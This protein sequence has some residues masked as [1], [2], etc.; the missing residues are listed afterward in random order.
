MLLLASPHRRSGV[1][2]T[3]PDL[4]VDFLEILMW[5][6]AWAKSS[7]PGGHSLTHWLP[8]YRH[9]DDSAAVAR[10]L[11]ERWVPEQVLD[12][13]AEDL[14]DGR[15]GV[16]VVTSWL[17]GVHDVG[18]LSPAFVV[19]APALADLM[20]RHG[21]DASPRLAVDQ[22]RGKVTHALVG[23]HAVRDWLA[24]ELGFTRRHEA[25]QWAVVIGGHHGVPP[26]PGQ[27]ALVRQ[28]SDLSGTGVWDEARRAILTRAT[29]AVGGREA[30][31]IYR[32]ALLSPPSQ[33][34]LT[35]IVVL[36]DWIASND[37][38]FPHWP[39]HTADDPPT[40]LDEQAVAARTK[41]RL[42]AAWSRL[43]LPSRWRASLDHDRSIDEHFSSRFDG[44]TARP[45]QEAT[46]RAARSSSSAGML[47]VEAPMGSG[48]TE[49]ALLAAETLAARSGAGGDIRRTADAGN[50]GRDVR[51]GTPVARRIP[52]VVGRH[53]HACTRQ[54]RAQ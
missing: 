50:H 13:I 11:V 28:R 9:L 40:E 12:R 46:I 20:R 15:D 31:R 26:E 24:T 22:D 37:K 5:S 49:A 18:K 43:N 34:L 2:C 39:I 6:V 30:L 16:P 7:P 47:I 32:G 21:L 41:Q 4:D 38:L 35:G 53:H 54:G 27:L 33:V 8:L 3:R 51:Q 48:K 36:A 25:A 14:P 42:A 10:R 1:A 23:H 19:Q 29:H 44:M 45:V 17:A 52:Q